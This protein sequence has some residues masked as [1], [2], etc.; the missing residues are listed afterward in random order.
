[1]EQLFWQNNRDRNCLIG[2]V[3]SESLT[4]GETFVSHSRIKLPPISSGES[5]YKYHLKEDIK[6]R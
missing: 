3:S 6:I 4:K 2:G 1:M 5:N